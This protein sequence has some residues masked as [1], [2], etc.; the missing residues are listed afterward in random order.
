MQVPES[1]LKPNLLIVLIGPAASLSLDAAFGPSQP[2]GSISVSELQRLRSPLEEELG[3]SAQQHIHTFSLFQPNKSALIACSRRSL[4]PEQAVTWAQT[5]LAAIKPAAVIAASSILSLE[6]RGPGDATEENL[7][8]EIHTTT[9]ASP[10]GVPSLPAGTLITGLPAA[11]LQE[12]EVSGISATVLT[13]VESSPVP[14]VG[15]VCALGDAVCVT[16][17]LSAMDDSQRGMVTQSV[18]GVYRSS[19]SNS[20]FI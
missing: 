11:L 6:Y 3:A 14:E 20:M 13:A 10:N 9:S 12:C 7:I 2:I 5:V 17:G 16:A 18:E 15:L 8:F 4:P 1:S 19:A